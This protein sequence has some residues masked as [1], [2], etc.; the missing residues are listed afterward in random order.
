MKAI[1]LS[2]GAKLRFSPSS[3]TA[4]QVSHSSYGFS[5][6]AQMQ[7]AQL[8]ATHRPA[9]AANVGR[10]RAVKQKAAK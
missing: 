4:G 6:I 7:A 2:P 5:R 9:A 3:G 8:R 1:L 10:A